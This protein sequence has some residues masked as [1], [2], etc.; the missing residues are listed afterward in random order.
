MMTQLLLDASRQRMLRGARFSLHVITVVLTVVTTVR[1]AEAGPE[2]VI[3]FIAA[4]LFLG[5][6]GAGASFSQRPS[7]KLWLVGLATLWLA[8]LVLSA[9]FVWLAFPLLLLAGHLLRVRW[10]VLFAAVVLATAIMAPLLHHGQTSFAHVVGPV[11]GGSFALGISL[12]YDALLRDAVE[13]ETLIESLLRAQQETAALQDELIRT[14][15]EAGASRER[16][17][18]AR[19][20]HDT[21]AQELSSISLLARTAETDR[22]PQIDALAQKSLTELRRIVAALD[23]V[24]LEQSALAE[25]LQ[26][27]LSDLQS[28]SEIAHALDVDTAQRS[29]PTAAEVALLRVAQS[30]L[31]NVRQ[32]SRATMVR[33]ALAVTADDATLEIADDGVG[34]DVALVDRDR[35]NGTSY[36]LAAMRARLRDLGGDLRVHSAAETGTA[37][38]ASIPLA[39]VRTVGE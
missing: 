37:L 17:R 34:F 22:M 30:A 26:R 8:L 18:L 39:P 4:A 36:G 11:V 1:A 32:H 10:A 13:R 14:Q 3:V 20:L 15:R 23:P 29:L 2:L 38:R 21:I 28:Q 27:M 5:W 24:E 35:A 31:A 33:M 19:D 25:A 6:Y 12:G 16:T 9:E 7:A